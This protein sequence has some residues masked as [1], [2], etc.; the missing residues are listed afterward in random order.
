MKKSKKRLLEEELYFLKSQAYKDYK[1]GL[2][3]NDIF[4]KN[5]VG[6]STIYRWIKEFKNQQIRALFPLKKGRSFGSGAKV[7]FQEIKYIFEQ[8]V[9]KSPLEYGFKTKLWNRLTLTSFIENN[10]GIQLSRWQHE[11]NFKQWGLV[12]VNVYILNQIFHEIETSKFFNETYQTIKL[13]A[14]SEKRKIYWFSSRLTLFNYLEQSFH[15]SKEIWNLDLDLLKYNQ[16]FA[17]SNRQKVLF[18]LIDGD[19]DQ[20]SFLL[21]LDHLVNEIDIKL[22]LIMKKYSFL[23]S[24]N[25]I[26]KINSLKDKLKIKMVEL[27]YF[28]EAGQRRV[29]DEICRIISVDRKAKKNRFNDLIVSNWPSYGILR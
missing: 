7:G 29:I 14:K 26:N 20:D 27:P 12:P 18:K 9:N 15:I 16:L 23:A 6:I 17:V 22:T 25:V 2:S 8:I 3:P 13:D 11:R 1:R 28:D 24:P 21:F 10:L 4:K 5:N 19:I